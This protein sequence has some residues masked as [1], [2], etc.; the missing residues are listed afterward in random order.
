MH[1]PKFISFTSSCEDSSFLS[2][3][4]LPNLHWSSTVSFNLNDGNVEIRLTKIISSNGSNCSSCFSLTD[5]LSVTYDELKKI[6][7]C[8]GFLVILIFTMA[9]LWIAYLWWDHNNNH[10]KQVEED[11]IITWKRKI[12]PF[13]S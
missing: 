1:S 3:F 2:S 5:G 9:V 6:L 8:V 4:Q 11:E 13:M 12:F 7:K 10:Y